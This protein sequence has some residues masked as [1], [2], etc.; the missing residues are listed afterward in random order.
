MTQNATQI[1]PEIIW[2]TVG[3]GILLLF[4]VAIAV[5]TRRDALPGSRG[6]REASGKLD[7]EEIRPEGFIE[8]FSN[9]VDS[10]RAGL[11]LVLKIA[12][13]GVLLWWL[14]YLIFNWTQR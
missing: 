1:V 5:R 11:P 2:I 9:D 4:G 12:V 8:S 7:V 14:L 13:P 6:R 3:F 10:G